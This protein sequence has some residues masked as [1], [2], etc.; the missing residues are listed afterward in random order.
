MDFNLS[1]VLSVFGLEKSYIKY[2]LKFLRKNEKINIDF[3][4]RTNK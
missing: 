1:L 3:F 4:N 2:I